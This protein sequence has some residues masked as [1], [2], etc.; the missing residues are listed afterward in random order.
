MDHKTSFQEGMRKLEQFRS[1]LDA[2][3]TLDNS[4]RITCGEALKHPFVVEK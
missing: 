3:V 4:K 1:L 2:M